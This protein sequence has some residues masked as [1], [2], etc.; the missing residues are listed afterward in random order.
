[1]HYHS[2]VDKKFRN[3]PMTDKGVLEVDIK[4]SID[5]GVELGCI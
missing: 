3:P 5:V 2:V 1:M 4:L